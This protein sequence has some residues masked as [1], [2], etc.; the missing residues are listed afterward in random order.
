MSN[1]ESHNKETELV[2]IA[3]KGYVNNKIKIKAQTNYYFYNLESKIMKKY[4]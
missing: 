1:L 4:V 3:Y 2:K